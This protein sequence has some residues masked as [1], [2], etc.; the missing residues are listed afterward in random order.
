[1]LAPSLFIRCGQFDLSWESLV[2]AVKALF[3]GGIADAMTADSRNLDVYAFQYFQT[4]VEVKNELPCFNSEIPTLLR[5]RA[6]ERSALLQASDTR[7]NV[8]GLLGLFKY[9]SDGRGTSLEVNYSP[10][11]RYACT[12]TTTS[13]AGPK[14]H[15]HQTEIRI[16]VY[17]GRS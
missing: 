15:H 12:S 17:K 9:A 2:L 4:M 14:H 3:I 1:M 10:P 13:I 8:Y 7:D 11:L 6:F 5:A 16:A